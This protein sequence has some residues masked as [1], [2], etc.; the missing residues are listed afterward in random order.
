MEITR[1]P[2]QVYVTGQ[3]KNTAAIVVLENEII[4]GVEA[5]ETRMTA[6][7]ANSGVAGLNFDTKAAMDGD[8]AHAAGTVAF[9]NFD[10]TPAN[11][12]K[13]LKLLGSGLGSWSKVD[14]RV[15][16]ETN[17]ALDAEEAIRDEFATRIGAFE[18][19]LADPQVV[20]TLAVT[21]GS[22]LSAGLY[23]LTGVTIVNPGYLRRIAV[24]GKVAGALQVKR[25][26]LGTDGVTYT[27]EDE[28]EVD[29]G[30]GA[31]SI[32]P[33]EAAGATLSLVAGD[34]IGFYATSG[35]LA[36]N[37]Q[38]PS[39]AS[40]IVH[41]ANVNAAGTFTQDSASGAVLI[42]AGFD[43]VGLVDTV[44]VN[45]VP[46]ETFET[47]GLEF[48]MYWEN[49]VR[50]DAS[51]YRFDVN[52]VGFNTPPA[53]QRRLAFTPGGG[54]ADVTLSV[55]RADKATRQP[56]QTAST[57]LHTTA[58]NLKAGVT[59]KVLVIGDSITV[60]CYWLQRIQQICS[61]F[62]NLQITFVGS[63]HTNAGGIFAFTVS[64]VT[65]AP[66]IG[67][68]YTNNGHSFTV[69]AID[70]R[71]NCL[72]I[73]AYGNGAAVVGNLTKSSGAYG[74]ALIAFSAVT[75]AAWA[76][77]HE[78]RGGWATGDYN[79]AGLRSFWKFVCTGVAVA[80]VGNN[81]VGLTVFT[82]NGSTFT[83]RDVVDNGGGSFTLICERTQGA[84]APSA[85]GNLAK[86][87]GTGD[88]SIAYSSRTSVA[89]NPFWDGAENSLDFYLNGRGIGA[90]HIAV[91]DIV[92]I[93][94]LTNNEIP[95]T[96][97]LQALAYAADAID[98]IQAM[99]D[100]VEAYNT[101]NSTAIKTVLVTPPP[102]SY[103]E[104]AFAANYGT[105]LSRFHVKANW[106]II[107]SEVMGHFGALTDEITIAQAHLGIDTV[108]GMQ[109]SATPT[110]RSAQDPTL[111]VLQSN[112]VH[113][114]PIGDAQRGDA[115]YPVIN[116]IA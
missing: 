68:V 12:G 8:L 89:S 65:K 22:D 60:F 38:F 3:N 91:P 53:G 116:Y 56:I 33:W 73:V 95:G 81:E 92:L 103:S 25:I 104:D 61:D 39:T 72:K 96:T 113:P 79:G 74:D 70:D 29:F 20:G 84:N 115:V 69:L 10:P 93:A 13:Y 2:A 1:T 37:V 43:I 9:V 101:D 105:T 40:Y 112:G 106:A 94:L 17:R 47:E 62:G 111:E 83:C 109:F 78:G 59:R 42:E 88:A 55:V 15:D 36:F 19:N 44:E 4:D 75:G 52:G 76:T 97:D 110:P 21:T 28:I 71:L 114:G 14:D 32:D 30:V 77:D 27:V 41:N 90:T 80:P 107:V 82:N 7:E 100:M 58:K 86:S 98:D 45:L 16:N 64:N 63:R 18:E 49:T 35:K 50:D 23:V 26:T 11:N 66:A 108:Y 48:S 31:N 51:A 54:F 34:F 67:T 99:V 24:Y 87:S 57:V 46:P 5:V 6:V 102:P 85:S